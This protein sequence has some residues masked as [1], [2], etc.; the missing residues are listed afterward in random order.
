MRFTVPL[1]SPINDCKFT[2]RP[3][4][5]VTSASVFVPIRLKFTASTCFNSSSTARR[6]L[7]KDAL[8]LSIRGKTFYILKTFSQRSEKDRHP[9]NGGTG[10]VIAFS[11]GFFALLATVGI[12]PRCNLLKNGRYIL[13][14]NM[15]ASDNYAPGWPGIT[16]RW[17]SSA[18]SGVGRAFGRESRLWFT[19]SHGIINEIYYPRVDEAC[20]RDIGLIV[21]D[22]RDFVSE[23]KRHTTN[24]VSCLAGGVPAY[25][26]VN[27]CQQGR[28][29]I[30]KEIVADP[31]RAVLLQQTRFEAL[32][33]ALADYHLYVLLAPHLGNWGRGNTAWVGDY[34]GWPMLF[35]IREDWAL[36]LACSAPW[37][38]RSVGFAGS[39][40]GWQ[41]LAAHKRLTWAYTRAE[42]GNVALTAEVDLQAAQGQFLLA[43]GFGRTTAE[44]GNGALAALQDGFVEAQTEYIEEW[45][46]WQ[47]SLLPLD[48]GSTQRPQN[49]YRVSAMVLHVHEDMDF[50]GGVIAS[51]SIPW[52]STRSD[53]DLGGYHLVWPRDLI[54]T[55]GGLLAAGAREDVSRVMGYLQSTQEADGHWPQNMW[56]DGT[57]YW[58]G[59]QMDAT[60]LP[61]LHAQLA[62]RSGNLTEAEL[63]RFWPTL[64]KA[65]GFL[66]CNGPGTQ[67]DRWE[68]NRGY[69]PFTVAAEIAAL[70]V[71]ADL[72]ELNQEPA[73]AAYLRETAD[74]WNASLEDWLY[75]RNT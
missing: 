5:W 6:S 37:L 61:I 18:K 10:A 59:I 46:A 1:K 30:E 23:E 15:G 21:T 48:K 31:Q 56:L 13:T 54:E 66:I 4:N 72:A 49:L 22:G 14:R 45:Q 16:P 33:G 74:D 40:D 19:L 32:Q 7:S 3:R 34:K 38:G 69:T 27:T 64:R 39:S 28:Y 9:L 35:A 12:H 68:E 36:A 20:T 53:D 43:V 29:R 55:A 47:N 50:Q 73:L 17:T 2:L 65:A 52:G 62:Q 8:S 26:L 57:P 58:N 67:Q 25:R 75:V 11:P 70:L 63:A 44:A 51:L 71:A 42:N 24:V 41:D 60:A